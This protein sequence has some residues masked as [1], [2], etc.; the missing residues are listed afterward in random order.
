MTSARFRP[1]RRRRRAD[2]AHNADRILQAAIDLLQRVPHANLDEIAAAAQVSRA[3]VYRH[4]GSRAELVETARRR[5]ADRADANQTDALR[6]AGEL[7]GGP[8]PS[9]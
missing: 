4:F 8:T 6:P 7:A 1:R 9:T 2:A 3:T 5:A